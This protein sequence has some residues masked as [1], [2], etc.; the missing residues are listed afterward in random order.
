M[1]GKDV[2]HEAVIAEWHQYGKIVTPARMVRTARWKY[3]HY[4]GNG[5]EL[6]DLQRDPGEV[7]NLLAGGAR[8][9]ASK[10][11][12]EEMHARM[13]K[14]IEETGDKFFA[15]EPTGCGGEGV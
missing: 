6:Y 7:T 3:V 11:V 10:A 14:H 12:R 9:A 2:S 4:L 13:V 1:E 5:E 15:Y 8:D